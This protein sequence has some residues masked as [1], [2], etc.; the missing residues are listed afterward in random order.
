MVA[1]EQNGG[2]LDAFALQ[3]GLQSPTNQTYKPNERERGKKRE[4][5]NFVEQKI[6][7]SFPCLL[8][9]KLMLII[10]CESFT[11][12]L[13][14]RQWLLLKQEYTTSGRTEGGSDTYLH[15]LI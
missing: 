14:K 3:K 7:Y 13:P 10:I 2:E 12:V 9:L 1:K 5:A 4:A 6:S 8:E 15:D 11:N